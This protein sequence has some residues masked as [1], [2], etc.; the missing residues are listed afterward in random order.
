MRADCHS[1][2]KLRTAAAEQVF[3]HQRVIAVGRKRVVDQ[4]FAGARIIG[5]GDLGSIRF[6]QLEVQIAGRSLC[7]CDAGERDGIKGAD[8]EELIRE[9]R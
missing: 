2:G 6:E 1:I 9:P 3:N 8:S 4:A 7:A 5:D